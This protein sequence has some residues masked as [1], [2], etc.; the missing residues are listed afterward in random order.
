MHKL[1]F[2]ALVRCQNSNTTR[3]A[4]AALGSGAGFTNF[5][6]AM[7]FVSVGHTAARIIGVWRHFPQTKGMFG[8]LLSA[9]EKT[10]PTDQDE[11]EFPPPPG[12]GTNIGATGAAHVSCHTLRRPFQFTHARDAPNADIDGRR[13]GRKHPS[14]PISPFSI[15]LAKLSVCEASCTSLSVRF[16]NPC[17]S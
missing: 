3:P 12:H 14:A 9:D 10:N 16:A 5:N 13:N 1:G 15:A 17:K 6:K 4:T 8:E 7:V 11:A 2:R